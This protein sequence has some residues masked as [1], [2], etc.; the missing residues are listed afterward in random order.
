MCMLITNP[1]LGKGCGL[2]NKL[3][4]ALS[5][6]EVRRLERL[7]YIS[8]SLS[9][10]GETWKLT[11]KGKVMRKLLSEDKSLFTKISDFFYKR[12]LKYKVYLFNLS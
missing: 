4:G 7:G 1:A 9:P 2:L 11:H 12:I 8:T 3:E 6:Q 10:K 5:S